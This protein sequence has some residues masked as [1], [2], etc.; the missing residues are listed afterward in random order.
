MKTIRR[1]FKTSCM[2][3]AAMCGSVLASRSAVAQVLDQV[4]S[5]ALMVIKVNHIADTNT[6][7]SNLMQTL[8][9]A[10]VFPPAK[11]PIGAIEGQSGLGAGLDTKRDAAAVLLNGKYDQSAAPPP[12]VILL[13]VSDYKAFLG[14]V[15]VVRTEG[16]VSVVHF[17]DN[18][19][20]TFVENWGG[21]AAISPTK[22]NVTSKHE[23]LKPTGSAA[24]ELD[25]NDFC[26]YV[27]GLTLKSVLLPKLEQGRQAAL[28]Q[29]QKNSKDMD[30]S[31]K[32]LATTALDQV[33]KGA[34]EFLNDTE[35]VTMG[36]N[37]GEKGISGN[38]V[39]NFVPDS[40]LGNMASSVKSVDGPLL[41]GLPKGTYL[42][43][44][45]AQEDPA[46][47]S[48]FIDDAVGPIMKDLDGLGPDGKK[49]TSLIEVYKQAMAASEGGSFGML[50][51]T[52][53]LGQGSLLK[54]VAVMKGDAE[55][56]KTAQAQGGDAQNDLMKMFGAPNAD[57]TKTTIT[58]DF[59]T[60]DGV[61]FDRVLTE[62]NPDNTSQAA[63]SAAEMM[64]KIYGPDGASVISGVVDPKTTVSGMGLDD[65]FVGQVIEAAKGNKD[66]LT[67]DLK[68]V[69]AELPAKRSAAYYVAVDQIVQTVL[70]YARANGVAL[71]VQ[72][73][74]N[75]PPI[76]FNAGAT[77][78]S[79][80][81]NMF[82]PNKLTHALV[83][84][85]IAAYQ[86]IAG[87]GNGGGL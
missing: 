24:K 78:P 77:G 44:G 29:L 49:L 66:V 23:G 46:A 83:Q 54:F 73:P 57:L 87:K 64:N 18:E 67:D 60:I 13:P 62:V 15:T 30:E 55:K 9:V 45:G 59:K 3:A 31:K 10:D 1:A 56:L 72:L 43:Y 36:L 7:I 47:L 5:D 25:A 63:M 52:A 51:P 48:K 50:A 32:K 6:K 20:D 21:Y 17:K 28:D 26:V 12:M 2:L 11:D 82:V 86:Q 58:P 84:A 38:T 79:L 81:A 65:D 68:S 4:P 37:I 61:K 39:L 34:K 27:N 80:Q 76:A 19:E 16:D 74:N 40:Y 70:S 22:E 85:G 69:D 53:A 41:A 35:S 14:S 42:V 33:I 71:P 75:L 8:G